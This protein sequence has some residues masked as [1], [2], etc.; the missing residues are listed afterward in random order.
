MAKIMGIHSKAPDTNWVAYTPTISGFGTCTNI[1][2][3]WK[4]VDDFLHVRGYYTGGT[5]PGAV[6]GTFTLPT[7]LVIDATKIDISNTTSA[8]GEAVGWILP[9][10]NGSQ[11]SPLV[12]AVATSTALIYLG[13]QPA[14]AANTTP[15]NVGSYSRQKQV[16]RR[17]KST[18][19]SLLLR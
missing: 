5:S 10:T 9:G 4:R 6:P 3:F 16:D 13:G 15:T 2:F 19:Y 17:D 14:S 11:I 7:G 8:P 12:T 18:R 1:S